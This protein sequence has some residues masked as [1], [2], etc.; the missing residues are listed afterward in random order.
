[1]LP[2]FKT[3]SDDSCRSFWGNVVLILSKMIISGMPCQWSLRTRWMLTGMV[4]K[5]ERQMQLKTGSTK[6]FTPKVD[7][8]KAMEP[9]RLLLFIEN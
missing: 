3:Y 7:D 5:W 2:V 9:S 6:F 1:M 4:Q 8:R